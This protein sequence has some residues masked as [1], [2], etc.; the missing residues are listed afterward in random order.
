VFRT[1]FQRPVL[2][3]RALQSIARQTALAAGTQ[4]EV[5]IVFDEKRRAGN[6]DPRLAAFLEANSGKRNLAFKLVASAD[7]H[8]SHLLN[9][10]LADC[11]AD[12]V[13]IL[14]DDDL[15]YPNHFETVLTAFAVDPQR[16]A[17]YTA[18]DV[19]HCEGGDDESP[20]INSGR[21]HYALWW[22]Y[23]KL[24]RRNAFPIQ[25]V[26]FRNPT[27]TG[28]TFDTGL[29]ALEDWEFWIRLLDD[30]KI[31]GIPKRT[32]AYRMPVPGSPFWEARVAHHIRYEEAVEARRTTRVDPQYSKAEV[33]GFVL[34]DG[35]RD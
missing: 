22:S 3:L 9:A 28:I 33:A 18:S 20:E 30:G 16:R 29:D 24:L 19:L 32:S 12:F 4:C 8:R 10:A 7:G 34:M 6:A 5:R 31:H 1:K 15:F 13:T 17:V 25:G 11:S 2:L 26:M 14:D 27:G 35:R 23:R 21:V